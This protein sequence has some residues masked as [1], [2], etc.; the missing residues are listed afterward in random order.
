M[1]PQSSNFGVNAHLGLF[2]ANGTVQQMPN[3]NQQLLGQLPAMNPFSFVQQPQ[4]QNINALASTNAQVNSLGSCMSILL[5]F[6]FV[7][8]SK[9]LS[10]FTK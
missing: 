9:W 3:M 2:N 8:C 7:V 4:T 10:V 6:S 1:G 5:Y